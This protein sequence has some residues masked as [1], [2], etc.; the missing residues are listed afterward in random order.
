MLV[1]RPGIEAIP[2]AV[3]A[4]FNHWTSREVPGFLYYRCGNTVL[5]TFEMNECFSVK[6]D[7]IYLRAE[8][9]M[10]T[11]VFSSKKRNALYIQ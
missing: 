3:E 11:S 9:R 2:L 4:L 1:P 5:K 8:L 10:C 7:I 6:V